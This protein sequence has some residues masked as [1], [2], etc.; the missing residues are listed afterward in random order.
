MMHILPQ[1]RFARREIVHEWRHLDI[2]D[3]FLGDDLSVLD[4]GALV[5][6]RDRSRQPD[7]VKEARTTAAPTLNP[8][9][10][11]SRGGG[12]DDIPTGWYV[13]LVPAPRAKEK[14][15]DASLSLIRER[16]FAATTV[17]ELCER[18]G[19]TKGA[20]FHHFESKDALGV[21][22][23]EHWSRTTGLLFHSAPYHQTPDALGRI[24]AYLALRKSLIRGE[25]AQFTCVAGTLVQET[26]ASHPRIRAACAES[27]FGHAQTLVEDFA[28]AM[29]ERDVAAAVTPKSLAVHTQC[30]L[31]GAFIL[32][33]TLADPRIA[34]E[35]V[36]HLERYIELLFS[37]A[38]KR[39]PPRAKTRPLRKSQ[40]PSNQRRIP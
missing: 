6:M 25:L 7:P 33:K 10:V 18:A 5:Y 30:V 11:R 28:A 13:S 22:A 38:P 37:P 39:R 4:N 20:F 29:K 31:Q 24:R 40:T 8:R 21:A 15:L 34:V 14:L 32:A 1:P 35:S 36:E 2:L 16:G 23:V 12:V 26:Y 27:I 17:D 19:V 3:S 9:A